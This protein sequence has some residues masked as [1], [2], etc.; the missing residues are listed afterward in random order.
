M[1]QDERRILLYL[2]Q[3][4]NWEIWQNM[5][6]FVNMHFLGIL[7]KGRVILTNTDYDF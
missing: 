2:S 6:S 5:F 7:K 4:P 3:D 1:K